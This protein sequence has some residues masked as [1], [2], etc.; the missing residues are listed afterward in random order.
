MGPAASQASTQEDDLY[1]QMKCSPGG[2]MLLV[3]LHA[4]MSVMS[5]EEIRH[6]AGSPDLVETGTRLA[7]TYGWL[8]KQFGPPN[9]R[10]AVRET[11]AE[12]LDAR[13]K[14]EGAISAPLW[15]STTRSRSEHSFLS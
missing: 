10:A 15:A 4:D 6:L 11:A 1:R 14:R 7:V 9:A 12:L 13:R 8:C 3:R 2:V 5:P